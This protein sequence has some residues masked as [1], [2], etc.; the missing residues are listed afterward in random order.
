MIA[1]GSRENGRVHVSGLSSGLWQTRAP[2]DRYLSVLK[3]FD[4]RTFVFPPCRYLTPL[5]TNLHQSIPL[6]RNGPVGHEIRTSKTG[7]GLL[8]L[9]RT[10]LG[11]KPNSRRTQR[12]QRK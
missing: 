4:E 5:C 10:M 2:A 3:R 1:D 7:A 6:T 9:G 8:L 12:A 11:Q